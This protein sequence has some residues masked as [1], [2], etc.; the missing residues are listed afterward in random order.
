MAS[1]LASAAHSATQDL[2]DEGAY[3]VTVGRQSLGL[4]YFSFEPHGDSI[5]V[6]SKVRQVAKSVG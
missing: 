4:E 6:F 1:A 2:A 5:L 3:Q